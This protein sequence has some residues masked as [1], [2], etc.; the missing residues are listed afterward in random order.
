MQES[1]FLYFFRHETHFQQDLSG[2]ITQARPVYK[3]SDA[4]LGG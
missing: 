4:T 2:V 3:K 1:Y